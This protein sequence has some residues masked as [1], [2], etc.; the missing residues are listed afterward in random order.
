[1]RKIKANI[2]MILMVFKYTPLFAIASIIIIAVD[3]LST[4]V[5][6]YIGRSNITNN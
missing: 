6:L 4:L 5:D 1:M 2:K 3:V